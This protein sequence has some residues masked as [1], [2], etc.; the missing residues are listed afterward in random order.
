MVNQTNAIAP[1]SGANFSKTAAKEL[2]KDAFLKLLVTQLK[3]Q[4]PLSPMQDREFISQMAQFSA[5]EQMANSALELQKL[6]RIDSLA[7]TF[8]LLGATVTY[9]DA[10]G[11]EV[12]GT[13]IGAE[14]KGGV[15]QVRVGDALVDLANIVKVAK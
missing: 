9:K 15:M 6:Q 4:D 14:M 10:A 1:T 11:K 7:T 2:D 8:S 3:Y 12:Q 5:L 13:V